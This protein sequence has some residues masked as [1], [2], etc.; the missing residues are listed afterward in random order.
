MR[1]SRLVM[2]GILLFA[3]TPSSAFPTVKCKQVCMHS[4]LAGQTICVLVF[5]L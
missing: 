4:E 1:L 2:L 3:S 5:G